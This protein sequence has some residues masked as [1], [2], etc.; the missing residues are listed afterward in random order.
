MQR[1][2]VLSVG[3]LI[4]GYTE[5]AERIV[6][7]WKEFQTFAHKLQMPFFYVPGNH[8]LT[9]KHQEE[10]WNEKFGRRYYSFNYRNVLFLV[11]SSEDNPGKEG[12]EG[13][14]APEQ[15]EF[16]RKTLPDNPAVRWTIVSV[17]RP[18]WAQ[19]NLAKN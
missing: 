13:F 11:L 10:V 1:E 9:N 17:H 3:D 2:F 18:L 6:E 7:Q 16:V 15:I 14:M 8:A 5:N 4:E 12:K 19:E